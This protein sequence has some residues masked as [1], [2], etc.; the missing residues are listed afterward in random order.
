VIGGG[1]G[2]HGE[3]VLLE[4]VRDQLETMTPLNAPPIEVSTLG[5]EAV[6]L[7]ALAIGLTTTR[8]IVFNRAVAEPAV[9]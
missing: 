5:R 3:D 1:L 2:R 6:V 9:S 8:E 7:G 4:V